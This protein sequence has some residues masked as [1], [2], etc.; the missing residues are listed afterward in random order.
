MFIEYYFFLFALHTS[1]F[2]KIASINFVMVIYTKKKKVLKSTFW[3]GD[4]TD[5]IKSGELLWPVTIILGVLT[6]LNL[7]KF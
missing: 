4:I 5:K 6:I 3:N 1:K 7:K 2:C